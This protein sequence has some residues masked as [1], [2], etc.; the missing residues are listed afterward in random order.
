MMRHRESRVPQRVAAERGSI[1]LFA[2]FVCLAVAVLVQ[3]LSVVVL[4]A[5]NT[6]A[7]ED[8]GRSLMEE[9]DNA[10]ATLRQRVLSDWGPMPWSVIQEKPAVQGTVAELPDS[11]GWALAASARHSADISPIVVSAWLER[12]RDGLDLPLAGL[13][14]Q[15][16]RWTSGR[17][18]PWLEVDGIGMAAPTGRLRNVPTA[19]LVGP[20]AVLDNMASVWRLDDGW[21]ALFESLA[22]ARGDTEAPATGV[23]AAQGLGPGARV[24]TIRGDP[25]TTLELP[26]EWGGSADDPAL[27]VVTGGARFDVRNRGDLYGVVVV[28]DGGVLVD[29]TRIH[30]ALFATGEV[31]FGTTGAV[32]FSRSILR[33]ATDRS[34]VRDR[35][36]PGTRGESIG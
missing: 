35:L 24:S 34:L 36:V 21:R 16:A 26:Q 19:P 14:A 5:D 7:A 32:A 27:L 33:W 6:L 4:C 18:S 2:L 15:T 9:K 31:D 28:D 20:G 29:G 30:G 17:V 10:L 12:G 11:G 25:G 3:T 22:S 23:V 1:L 13:V 8:S